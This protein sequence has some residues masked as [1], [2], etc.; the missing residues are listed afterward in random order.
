M[1]VKELIKELE[2]YPDGTK[3]YI[4]NIYEKGCYRSIGIHFKYSNYE[5]K[6][7]GGLLY[8]R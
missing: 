4:P 2:N 8:I 5:R 6:V 7:N 1:T 3:V